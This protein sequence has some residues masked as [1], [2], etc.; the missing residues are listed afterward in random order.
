[1]SEI[2]RINNMGEL[3]DY[4]VERK[5][6]FSNLTCKLV[7]DGIKNGEP[8]IVVATVISENSDDRYDLKVFAKDYVGALRKNLHGLVTY[9]EYEL[10]AEVKKIIDENAN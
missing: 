5:T 1:M 3:Y 10:A 4:M 6:Y 7:L 2:I 9:E 8:Y